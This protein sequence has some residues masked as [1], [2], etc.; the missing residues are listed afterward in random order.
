MENKIKLLAMDDEPSILNYFTGYFALKGYA[1]FGA[2]DSTQALKIVQEERPEI[3]ILD[4]IMDKSPLDGIQVLSEIKKFD[5]EILCIMVSRI[6]D[7]DRINEAKELGAFDFI[8]K[9]FLPADLK[10]VVT[11][12]AG[13]VIKKRK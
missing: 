2:L 13:E 3:C 9:P 6:M 7:N 11:S 8:V 4:I 5:K 12:A 10:K 1:T